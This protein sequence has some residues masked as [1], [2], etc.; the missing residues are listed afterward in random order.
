MKQAQ[1]LFWLP[2]IAAK[3]VGKKLQCKIPGGFC[4]EVFSKDL[5]GKFSGCELPSNFCIDVVALQTRDLKG[6]EC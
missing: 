2:V 5:Q 4:I 1:V 6:G 3:L